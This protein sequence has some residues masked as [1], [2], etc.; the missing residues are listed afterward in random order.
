MKPERWQVIEVL[1]HSASDVPDEERYSFLRKACEGDESLVHEVESLLRH[2]STPQSVLDGPAI[3]LMA[4]AMAVEEC[5]C[6]APL[7]EGKTISHYRIMEPIGRGGMGVVYKA[8]DLKL[9]RYVA[10]KLLPQFLATD[11]QALSRFEREAQA[12]SALNHPHHLHCL[13]DRRGR[14]TALHRHRIAGWRNTQTTNRSRTT[15]DF[16]DS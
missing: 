10:L 14:G 1:Y 4:K 7:L 8:E 6:G 3:A 15:R 9:R 11:P 16:P 2:G 5:E 12:A 13:R